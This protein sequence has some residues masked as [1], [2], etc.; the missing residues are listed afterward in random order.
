MAIDYGEMYPDVTA[1]PLTWPVLYRYSDADGN[2]FTVYDPKPW[3]GKQL[4]LARQEM[5]GTSGAVQGH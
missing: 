1:D 3:D 2:V 4:V 5:R